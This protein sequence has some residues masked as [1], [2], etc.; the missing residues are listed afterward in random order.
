MNVCCVSS[1]ESPHRGDS[2]ENTRYTFYNKKSKSP[3]IILW[4]F[5]N[6]LQNEFETAVVVEPS[7]FEPL[8]IY[9]SLDETHLILLFYFLYLFIYLLNFNIFLYLFIYLLNFNVFPLKICRIKILVNFFDACG[10]NVLL[11]SLLRRISF[12]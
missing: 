3:L 11:N 4:N 2:N 1:L 8:K 7:V 5:S 10:I 9:C 6:G 12:K